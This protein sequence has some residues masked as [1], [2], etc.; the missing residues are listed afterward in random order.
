M[1]EDTSIDTG[2]GPDAPLTE[3]VTEASNKTLRIRYNDLKTQPPSQL[4]EGSAF[5]SVQC[6][7]RAYEQSIPTRTQWRML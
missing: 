2:A 1:K 4:A 6:S 3:E 5:R 7:T